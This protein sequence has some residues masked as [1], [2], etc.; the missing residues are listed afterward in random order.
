MAEAVPNFFQRNKRWILPIL[1]LGGAV[2]IF[3]L[4]IATKPTAPSQPVKERVWTVKVISAEYGSYA[5]KLS[6]YGQIE[7][8]SSSTLSAPVTAFVESRNISEGELVEAGQL[9]L[10]L[11]NRDANLLLAQ[12]QA[13]M[14][15]IEA[16]IQAEKVRYQSD[17]KALKIEKELVNI[18]LRTLERYKNL[19][20]RQVASQNQLDDARRTK[21]QQALSL[22]SRQQAIND[23]PNRLAQLEAQLKQTKALRDIAAL[24][25]ERTRIIAPFPGRIA[26]INVAAG[27]R[28]RSGDSLL[29]I[30]NTEKLEVR[31]QI[32][33]RFLP[34]IRQQ[35]AA[36]QNIQASAELDGQQMNLTLERLAAAVE[37]GGIGIDGLF[38]IS[39][40][41]YSGEPGRSIALNLSMPE[42]PQLLALPPQAIFGTDRIYI[43][44]DQ[45]LVSRQIV[46]VGDS[47][48][49]NG[50]P[51]VLVQS[52]DLKAGDQILITQLPNAVTGLLV[53][54]AG[55]KTSAAATAKAE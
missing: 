11:D 46:R 28:V 41:D 19:S 10:K 35:L 12:R 1:I 48:D 17:L 32:P 42:Q 22:N 26:S 30:Y 14:E 8:P 7:A 33:S 27:D 29:N 16:Q 20:S 6:L 9:L 2:A 36:K 39:N 54:I 15:R 5:P 43:V 31:A 52:N 44:Q 55:Q 25:L 21:Q 13:D 23:H 24:D 40:N 34:V 38:S 37:G 47:L 50:K 4:L 53:K 51:L 3:V 49:Q 18:T 45:R